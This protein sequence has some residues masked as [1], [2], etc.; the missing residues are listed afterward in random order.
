MNPSGQ[1]RTEIEI[2]DV[3]V[4]INTGLK[5]IVGISG[6]TERGTVNKPVLV[7]SWIEYQREFGGTLAGTIFPHIVRRALENGGRLKVSRVAHYANI[8][9]A[10]T[11]EGVKALNAIT[12]SSVSAVGATNVFTFVSAGVAG[13][14][15]V[16]VVNN[17]LGIIV[18]GSYTIGASPTVT[19]VASGVAGVIN[20]LTSTHGYSASNVAGALTIT[21]PASEGAKANLYTPSINVTG[22]G[23]LATGTF[24]TTTFTSGVTAQTAYTLTAT[25]KSIGAWGNNVTVQFKAPANGVS[26]TVD[27]F[28]TLAGYPD[29][30]ETFPNISNTFSST[31]LAAVNSKSKLVDFS[32]MTGTISGGNAITL[33]TGAQ[34]V[35]NITAADYIGDGA[36]V[37]GIHSFDTDHDIVKIACPE[38]ANPL[39]D[40]ALANYADARK[41]LRAI[42][43]TPVGLD[44]QGI[45]GYRN[46]TSPYNHVAI[47]TWRASMF[48]GG[49]KV[50]NPF[51]S[52][53]E[54]ITEIGDVLGAYS[55]KDNNSLEWFTVGG[56]K[57]GLINNCLGIVYD[58]GSPA[59]ATN[60]DAVDVNGVNAVIQHE[61][62][63]PV[64][65]GNSTLQKA[66]TLLKHDNVAD[67][68]IALSRGLKPLV[69][70]ELFDPND[71]ITWKNIYRRVTPLMDYIQANR[72]IWK[73]LYQ[74]DQDIDDV[75]Q[76]VV[77]S[78][79]N[80]DAGQYIFNLFI[81]PKVGMKYQGV[82]VIVTNSDVKF[83]DLTA[84][85]ATA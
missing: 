32:G 17:G 11:I 75:S 50:V 78:P 39:V 21:A 47:N 10:S 73:Y 33:A 38:I 53:Q 77:N 61:T 55:R 85:V 37:T 8:A 69:Q 5:G 27:L 15:V 24:A 34:V 22:T 14:Q 84:A 51:T 42:V 64:I 82:K 74:G 26:G 67:L 60:A 41:D 2:V 54:E 46:G 58:L 30:D 66:N 83:E 3:S 71:V 56:P 65:W 48:T 44:A 80:I 72:G 62:F 9:D 20:A 4:L 7:G 57:R 12:Q 59:R 63:G 6:I 81:A 19:S 45:I 43:R 76:A 49:L 70:S 18:L 40:M 28:V 31:D 36:A 1:A 23:S 16:V 52:L 29:L 68:M 79:A 35:A 13:Q 25:A